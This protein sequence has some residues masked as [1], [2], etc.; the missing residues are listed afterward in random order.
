MSTAGVAAGHPATTRAGLTALDA[1]GNAAD[2]AVAAVM[3]SCAAESIMTGLGG[4]GFATHYDSASGQVTCLDFFVAVPG[5]DGG[6]ASA[7]PTPIEVSFGGV[8]L[9]FSIGAAS[10][11]VPGVPAGCAALHRRFGRL[12]WS[13]VLA[14]AIRVA[15][16]GAA[17]P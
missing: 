10:V 6:G 14:E 1:G 2:A 3:A 7:S 5:V 11:A 15:E 16:E 12:P 8:P 13:E 9:E 17:L 4:G